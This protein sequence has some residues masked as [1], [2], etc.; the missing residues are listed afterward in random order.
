LGE[1]A[2]EFKTGDFAVFARQPNRIIL[3]SCKKGTRTRRALHRR[4]KLTHHQGPCTV[5][6]PSA[7]AIR[8]NGRLDAAP[9]IRS[10]FRKAGGASTSGI[11]G[12]SGAMAAGEMTNRHKARLF[13][14]FSILCLR[15]TLSAK[16]NSHHSTA[17]SVFVN[18][19][20]D[21]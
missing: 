5:T 19:R 2:E 9:A 1:L 21:R 18:H 6:S 12:A 11:I 7:A 8:D 14:A 4:E 3:C 17:L 20:S 10:P 15:D 13:L 16:N